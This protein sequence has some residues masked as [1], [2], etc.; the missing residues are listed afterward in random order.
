MKSTQLTFICHALTDAQRVGRFHSME[1]GLRRSVEP[2]DWAGQGARV[3]IAPELRTRQTAE[4][5]GLS[6]QLDS[7]L[8]DCDFGRW[9]GVS[10]KRLEQDDPTGLQQW[11]SDPQAAPHGGE[12]VAQVCTRVASWMD[13]TLLPG[14]WLVVTHPMVIRAALRHVLECPLAALQHIDVL[15]LAQVRLS[16]FGRWRLRIE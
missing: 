13:D 9:Q 8:R 14:S 16:R 10:L 7:T 3:L 6:G 1:D 5:L 15:P 11:L 4:G 2:Q 12:S